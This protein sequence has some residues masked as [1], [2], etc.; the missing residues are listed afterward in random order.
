MATISKP[1][2]MLTLPNV[3][4]VATPSIG[5]RPTV[6]IRTPMSAETNPFT[7]SPFI[8]T[9]ASVS[10]MRAVPNCSHGPNPRAIRASADAKTIR[11]RV[12]KVPPQKLAQV[13]M[14][15]ALAPSPFCAIG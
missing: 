7:G 15:I 6:V 12:L 13:P 5:D 4:R 1:F 11:H 9:V 2:F 8:S 10:A 14:L 3:K